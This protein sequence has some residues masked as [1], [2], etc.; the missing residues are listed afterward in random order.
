MYYPKR[1]TK[2]IL[3][4][5]ITLCVNTRSHILIIF[6]LSNNYFPN[7]LEESHLPNHLIGLI[8]CRICFINY[9][10]T[11]QLVIATFDTNYQILHKHCYLH[12]IH[13]LTI[14]G[15]FYQIYDVVR[16][17]HRKFERTR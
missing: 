4:N 1:F 10:V 12:E 2:L 7:Y 15:L 11:R 5:N 17:Q 8:K 9:F 3:F 14:T 13:L 16:G 6:K